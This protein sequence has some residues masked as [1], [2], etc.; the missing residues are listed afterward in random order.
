MGSSGRDPVLWTIGKL[1]FSQ[2][3]QDF[4]NPE[5][6]VGALDCRTAPYRR[7]GLAWDLPMME[8]FLRNLKM[9]LI[10]HR[11]CENLIQSSSG[12]IGCM[13]MFSNGFRCHSALVYIRLVQ[14]EKIAPIK[15]AQLMIRSIGVT[16]AA[17]WNGDFY[18]WLPAFH[19]DLAGCNSAQS[20]NYFLLSSIPRWLF[21]FIHCHRN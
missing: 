6:Y 21:L 17:G 13:G 20:V 7:K 3:D 1:C 8:S 9:E 2:I 12:A 5:N 4:G 15:A 10:H 16:P 18:Y 14:F 19:G 11:A